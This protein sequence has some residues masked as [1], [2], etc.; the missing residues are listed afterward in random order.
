MP[1]V[2]TGDWTDGIEEPIHGRPGVAIKDLEGE[3]IVAVVDLEALSPDL[4]TSLS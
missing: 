4:A 2:G 3:A 1:N